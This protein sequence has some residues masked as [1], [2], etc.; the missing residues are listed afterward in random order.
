MK[1]IAPLKGSS[2]RGYYYQFTA[3]DDCTRLR[4]LPNHACITCAGYSSYDVVRDGWP[5]GVYRQGCDHPKGC[6]VRERDFFIP[7]LWPVL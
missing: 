3:I 1:F 2:K 7:I 4:V 5:D 6:E